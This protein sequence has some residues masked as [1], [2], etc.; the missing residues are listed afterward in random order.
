M[1]N[2]AAV[3]FGSRISRGFCV[4]RRRLTADG[5]LDPAQIPA[6]RRSTD[7][8]AVLAGCQPFVAP[9]RTPWSQAARANM[10]RER[11]AKTARTSRIRRFA[12]FICGRLDRSA[13]C[14]PRARA[15]CS[16][17][18]EFAPRPPCDA[19]SDAELRVVGA[20]LVPLAPE[21]VQPD[22]QPQDGDV[23]RDDPREQRAT[24][25]IQ[26]TPS[27]T[28]L[29]GSIFALRSRLRL[30]ARVLA[31]GLSRAATAARPQRDIRPSA[32]RAAWRR[33]RAGCGPARADSAG[34]P[35][36]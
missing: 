25:P 10:R 22:V 3:A 32:R 11:E 23:Q 24:T 14:G 15:G 8:R 31:V 33:P 12:S 18:P 36:G 1:G 30:R 13:V 16:P 2:D 26:T 4:D 29:R 35:S 27:A 9:A 20:E 21:L 7:R 28:R 19:I 34:S 6:T 5:E 17:G